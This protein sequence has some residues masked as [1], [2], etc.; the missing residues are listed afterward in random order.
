MSAQ[1]TLS[2]IVR[3][4]VPTTHTWSKVSGPGTVVFGDATAL[5]TTATFSLAGTYVLR[6]TAFTPGSQVGQDDVTI[7]AAA[8]VAPSVDAGPNQNAVQSVNI[9]LNGSYSDDNY[10]TGVTKTVTWSMTSGTG[11]ASFSN[12][13][14]LAPTV[15][16]STTGSKTLQLSVYDGQYTST[17]T[18][19]VN[20]AS[21][22]GTVYASPTSLPNTPNSTALT[23]VEY[24]V[25]LSLIPNGAWWTAVNANPAS[26]RV[27]NSGG[28]ALIPFDL[29]SFSAGSGST[30]GTGLLIFKK[31]A[32][33][34]NSNIRIYAGAS[35]ATYLPVNDPNGQYNAYGSDN[36]GFW[37]SGSG[38]DR[39]RHARIL[40]PTGTLSFT[41]GVAGTSSTQYQTNEY[42]LAALTGFTAP[43][44][45]SCVT[46]KDGLGGSAELALAGTCRTE[47]GTIDS[48][49]HRHYIMIG[50]SSEDCRAKSRDGDD[51]KL[52]TVVKYT[53]GSPTWHQYNGV[54]YSDGRAQAVTRAGGGTPSGAPG[55][56][57]L[58]DRFIVG[59]E[60]RLT[61]AATSQW[62][63]G[64]ICF[65]TLWNS[66]KHTDYLAYLE[67]MLNQS[68]FYGTWTVT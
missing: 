37:P 28:T 63:D 5:S 22:F 7:V 19:T 36:L 15:S 51:T 38:T 31:N 26:I 58:Q 6:L 61:P 12:A 18:M 62:L 27:T 29:A 65:L 39:T 42:S 20:V 50:G 60:C 32:A 4:G 24:R 52:S 2:G 9:T 8:N 45:I 14:I 68:T 40:Y 33:T 17:D 59:G 30:A 34:S 43:M 21:T 49:A 1:V 3:S 47:N 48:P 66:A 53:T 46:D 56:I 13:N 67:S 11:T 23:D 35:G 55:T 25:D 10:K 54:F 64:N 16:F 44:T 41:T 57:Q